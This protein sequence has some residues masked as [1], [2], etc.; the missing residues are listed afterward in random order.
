MGNGRPASRALFLSV[1]K[2]ALSRSFELLSVFA[3][4]EFGSV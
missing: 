2:P 4:R 3:V 1:P